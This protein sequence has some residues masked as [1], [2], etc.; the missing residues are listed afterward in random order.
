MKERRIAI[1]SKKYLYPWAFACL[2]AI[3][4]C[5]SMAIGLHADSFHVGLIGA[6]S[7]LILLFF[8]A[9]PVYCF[10]Y[11]KKIL[12]HEKRKYLLALYN[13]V[14]LTAFYCIPFW[15]EAET[16]LYSA[17]LFLWV[18]GW[19]VLPLFLQRRAKHPAVQTEG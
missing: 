12:I 6:L 19:S 18:M 9:I 13:A 4:I 15:T 8:G 11:G 3:G 14:V 5:I 16:Y 7:G 10:A 2:I 1:V 17:I